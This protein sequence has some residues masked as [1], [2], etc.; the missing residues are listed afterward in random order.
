M[1]LNEFKERY[2]KALP[3]IPPEININLNQF[4]IFPKSKVDLLPIKENEKKLLKNVGLPEQASPY[5]SF[6]YNDEIV[7]EKLNVIDTNLDDKFSIYII[8]G[9]NGTGDPICIHSEDGRIVYLDHNIKMNEIFINS[10][11]SQFVESICLFAE[12]MRS[13]CNFKFLEE[14]EKVDYSAIKPKGMWLSEYE[15]LVYD[16]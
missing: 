2:L 4:R 12:T 7:L 11:I 10:S 3:E 15:H 8:I 13:D 1:E 9:S 16:K 6:T 14:L 5:L